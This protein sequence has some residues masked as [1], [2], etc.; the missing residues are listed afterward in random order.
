M[1]K[2]HSKRTVVDGIQFASK[3]EARRYGELKLLDRAGLIQRLKLQPRYVL[4]EA[5]I[6]G[7][8][9][10]RAIEYVGDFEYW[11]VKRRALICEDVKGMRTP[12]YRLKRKMFL[13]QYPNIQHKEI[14]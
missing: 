2:Y 11:D 8:K 13:R 12:V 4:Q 5:F 10:I 3:A 7:G 14:A 9:R 6:H 1:S